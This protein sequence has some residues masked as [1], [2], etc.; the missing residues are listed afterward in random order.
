MPLSKEIPDGLIVSGYVPE[1]STIVSLPL[2]AGQPK[3]ALSLFAARTA[4]RNVQAESAVSGVSALLVTLIVAAL[5]LGASDA[6]EDDCRARLPPTADAAVAG[7]CAH[8]PTSEEGAS[9]AASARRRRV[10]GRADG[11]NRREPAL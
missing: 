6:A 9:P 5:A 4:S 2:P 8:V 7:L 1:P 3:P 10:R 11:R